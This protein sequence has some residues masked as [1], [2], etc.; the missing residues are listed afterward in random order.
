MNRCRTHSTN[1]KYSFIQEW[2]HS[3]PSPN[4]CHPSFFIN[5][6]EYYPDCSSNLTIICLLHGIPFFFIYYGISP[7]TNLCTSIN[8]ALSSYLPIFVLV[9]FFYLYQIY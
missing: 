4:H 7:K 5:D 8:V 2:K 1:D 6:E 3:S 9:I